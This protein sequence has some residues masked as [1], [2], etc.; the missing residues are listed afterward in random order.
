MDKTPLRKTWHKELSDIHLSDDEAFLNWYDSKANQPDFSTDKTTEELHTV[1]TTIYSA[2][3]RAAK[4]N[5]NKSVDSK[6]YIKKVWLYAAASV[7]FILSAG[8][9]I[10]F[11]TGTMKYTTAYGE[12]KA[13]TLP[14]HSTAVLNGNSTLTYD[15]KEGKTSRELW[16]EGE[17]SFKVMHTLN[18]EPFILH[19]GDSVTIHVLGTEFNVEHRNA[20]IAV[21]LK[22]GKIRLVLNKKQSLKHIQITPGEVIT[23]DKQGN[24]NLQKTAKALEKSFSWQ[25]KKLILNHTTL[26]EILIKIK[27]TQ[28]LSFKT[29][30]S[31]L[32]FRSASGTLPLDKNKEQLLSNLSELFDMDIEKG[33]TL[34][35]K[36][37]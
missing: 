36:A 1:K 28:G 10:R 26:G 33:N 24:T 12:I 5:N 21:A 4:I 34:Y 25:E 17:A 20:G 7:F 31:S 30:D 8:I 15:H 9:Y 14:D 18:R 6:R 19:V 13:V 37:R 16:L 3:K 22:S 32:L 27:E 2:I 35:L 23:F 11:H 29:N